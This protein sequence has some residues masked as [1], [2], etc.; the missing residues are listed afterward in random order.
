MAEDRFM[1][2]R[3]LGN[4]DFEITAIG[5][6][7]W[8]MGGGG[9]LY[10]WGPQDDAESTAAI[11]HAVDLGINWI[12]TAAVYG[13]GHSEEIV[14][15][16]LQDIPLC[17]RPWVFTKC[18]LI[19]DENRNVTHSLDPVSLR[20]E[21]ENS[22]RRL[23]VET[24]D[25]YQ[26]H[27]PRWSGATSEDSLEEAWLALAELQRQG[28][29]RYLGVS[30]FNVAQLERIRPIAPVSSLQPSYS[31]LS[32]GIEAEILP[33]CAAHGIGVIAY[34]PMKS[35][36]LSGTMTRERIAAFPEDDWRRTRQEFREPNLTHNLNLVEKLRAIGGRH[37]RSPAEVAIA[38]VLRLPAV[39]AAIVGARR[40]SQIDGF[41]GAAEFRLNHAELEEID[42]A[43]S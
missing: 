19:W 37:G 12:D 10:G 13:L 24:I 43:L 14:A 22:L 40:P 15:R 20:R 27:W 1:E 7:A 42:Q 6:G 41:I 9:W 30:N 25:L 2:K 39:T 23:R 34:S 3:R 38:W 17:E 35:G 21:L 33:Y 36:L 28:K 4:T 5:L 32:R 31:I 8:A 11:L 29:I 18:S 16:S 26:I